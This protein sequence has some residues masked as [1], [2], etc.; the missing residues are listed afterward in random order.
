MA[1][2]SVFS[3]FSAG[4]PGLR[5]VQTY[6]SM[7]VAMPPGTPKVAVLTH[8][9]CVVLLKNF[10]KEAHC[11]CQILVTKASH[12][13]FPD[14]L[15]TFR[16]TPLLRNAESMPK[17]VYDEVSADFV[18]VYLTIMARTLTSRGYFGRGPEER[19]STFVHRWSQCK[20]W[21]TVT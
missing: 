3:P 2:S 5:R 18:V 7:L 14:F 21:I 19:F 17:L 11:L 12:Q 9:I 13:S 20:A 15:D 4:L 1:R 8:A 16:V 6:M 10:L